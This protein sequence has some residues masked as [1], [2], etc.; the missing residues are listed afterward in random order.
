[1]TRYAVDQ[2]RNVLMANWGT[3]F[4]DIAT[5]V[6]ELPRSPDSMRLATTLTDL[7]HACWRCYTHPASSV[8]QSGGASRIGMRRQ[9][10]RDAFIVVADALIAPH[11]PANG[12]L[13]TCDTMVEDYA[14]RVG[15]ALHDLG[16][17]ELTARISVDVDAELAAVERAERGDLTERAQQAVTLS[18]EDASPLH[19]AQ[20]DVQ[21]RQNPF[22]ART[23]FTEF[24]PAAAAIAAAHWLHAAAIATSRR[25]GL[26]PAQVVAQAENAKP[27]AHESLSQVITAMV[28]GVRP[29]QAVMPMIRHA[30]HI[31]DGHLR[32]ITETKHRISALEQ[33]IATAHADDP[34]LDLD[35]VFL[36]ITPL[37][38]ARPALDLLENLL[39]GIRGC[40]LL[41]VEDPRRQH[42]TEEFLA[43]IRHEATVHGERL[44]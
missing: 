27:H 33:I 35:S 19:T 25:T 11:L 38:P 24:D 26:A 2:A 22:G 12:S 17:P 8:D 15:R 29:R 37:N 3:G 44:P 41:Y 18:R 13:T 21:L 36:P 14:H 4:G 43:E 31:A 28:A 7:S 16:A 9:R 6:A 20:A 30:L 40:W 5:D 39:C 42:L 23:L 10:E 1:M 32:G 34:D